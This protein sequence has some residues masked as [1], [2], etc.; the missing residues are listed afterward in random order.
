MA[1]KD[2]AVAYNGSTNSK[3][4]LDL[5]IQMC[6]K[7]AASLTGLY[8]RQPLGIEPHLSKWTSRSVM[9]A[10]RKAGDEAVESTEVDFR[11]SITTAAFD[12]SVEWQVEEG[13]TN[14]TLARL[15]LYHDV[16]LIGQ[17][18]SPGEKREYV[19]V[20]DL[21]QRS[22]R[23]LIVVPNGYTVRPF[24]DYAVV[25]WDDSR[26]AARALASAMHII[27]TKKRLDVVRV[28]TAK[29]ATSESKSVDPEIVRH[30][31]R[32]GI[33]A[34]TV[35]S[36]AR[37]DRIGQAILDHCAKNEP[38]VL[39]MGAYGH[40]RLREDIFGGV[41]RYILRHMNLPVFMTH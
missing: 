5:A 34:H 29:K 16:L 37:R 39:V 11:Q 33:A 14:E 2:L 26:P 27:E 24:A 30:L 21:V 4:A 6:K 31:K 28:G 12:G 10:L 22:G 36:T 8:V 15:A 23:P 19:R 7:Y 20:E 13:Q 9:E 41:T 40:A 25:A 1:I 32:H 18:S 38:D 3:A 17:F 35:D